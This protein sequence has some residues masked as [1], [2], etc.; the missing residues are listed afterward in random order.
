MASLKGWRRGGR[1]SLAFGWQGANLCGSQRFADGG[2]GRREWHGIP[3]WE[4]EAVVRRAPGSE[5]WDV[6]ADGKKFLVP[7]PSAG[8]G[9]RT[10]I[11]VVLNWQAELKQ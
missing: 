4:S 9:A 7:V 6:T 3:G 1:S 2:G 5:Q 11:T 8:Q 10:P